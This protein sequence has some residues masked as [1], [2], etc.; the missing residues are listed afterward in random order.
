MSQK[1]FLSTLFD[2]SFRNFLTSKVIKFIYVVSMIII[3]LET[4]AFVAIAFKANSA[5]GALTL[6]IFGPIYFVLVMMWIR[7]VLELVVVF[8]RIQEDVSKIA[9]TGTPAA[10]AGAAPTTGA[11]SDP[12]PA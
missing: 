9:G 5:L 3:A 10:V 11:V 2:F 8:F 12:S 7:I 6:L 1:G 4:I